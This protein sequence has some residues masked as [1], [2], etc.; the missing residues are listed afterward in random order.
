MNEFFCQLLDFFTK[1]GTY[2]S[3]AASL[4][5]SQLYDQIKDFRAKN[6]FESA[7]NNAVKEYNKNHSENLDIDFSDF[8]DSIAQIKNKD[9]I[10]CLA[11]QLRK[12]PHSY[13]YFLENKLND[14][15]QSNVIDPILKLDERNC[16]EY[17]DKFDFFA[18]Y[19]GSDI[20]ISDIFIDPEYKIIELSENGDY[21][22]KESKC[23]SGFIDSCKKILN[24]RRLLFISGPY[25]HGKTFLSKL[26]LS[27]IEDG[28]SFF[29]YASDLPE[30]NSEF[31]KTF[32]PK[33]INYFV[34]RYEKLYIFIDSFEDLLLVNTLKI[35]E[36]LLEIHNGFSNVYFVI[37]YR[38]SEGL[39]PFKD[40]YEDLRVYWNV[41]KVIELCS[42]TDSKTEQWMNSYSA[43]MENKPRKT[44]FTIYDIKKANK[45][46]QKSFHN[47][48][49]LLIMSL[50]EETPVDIN[51]QN[52]YS[53]FDNFVEKTVMGKYSEE[54]K[55][56]TFLWLR[57]KQK[58]Y[59]QFITEAA[60]IILKNNKVHYELE[61]LTQED[62]FLDQNDT[63]KSIFW[64]ED[65]EID[66]A[67]K[68]ILKINEK[69]KSK[70]I[71]RYLNCYFFECR[72]KGNSRYWKFRDNNILFFLCAS[73]I[74]DKLKNA[75]DTCIKTDVIDNEKAESEAIN[76]LLVSAKDTPLHPVIIEFLINEISESKKHKPSQIMSLIRFLIQN[77]KIL[78]VP[79]KNTFIL[80]Y[81]KINS[82]ILFFILYIHFHEDS[83][84]DNYDSFIFKRVTHYYSFI[85]NIDTDLA[86][87]IRRYFKNVS[88]IGV[89][90][91]G[92]NVKK[93][94]WTNS[95]ITNV[96]FLRCKID[97]SVFTRNFFRSTLFNL[98][99]IKSI[100]FKDF[101]GSL[102]FKSSE[103][104]RT[105]F[106]IPDNT[107]FEYRSGAPTL[108]FNN[109]IL[110]NVSI[111]SGP[112]FT[113]NVSL[114]N[115]D[116]RQL[117]LK[118]DSIRLHIEDSFF[119]APIDLNKTKVTICNT[120]TKSILNNNILYNSIHYPTPEDKPV[121]NEIKNKLFVRDQ[122]SA[123]LIEP[124]NTKN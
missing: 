68:E 36:Q 95:K 80:D 51:S 30:S 50:N 77:D 52:W 25:G 81:R 104:Y 43:M 42:F 101:G 78:Q 57:G 116:V 60:H 98:C 20:S 72:I 40:I 46:I 83:Y 59:K 64:V 117:H 11:E 61:K 107:V 97:E 92:I 3:L 32:D 7:F 63:K 29:F 96:K 5:A 56:N 75:Y 111:S 54:G 2:E 122:G 62:Y 27:E 79:D 86:A 48:L 87:V 102:E 71:E 19:P 112:E 37:N 18:I 113:P 100:L 123:I 38:T 90:F 58:E 39:R 12:S 121:M 74:C 109:C 99:Y 35:Q 13:L 16:A 45:N 14:I 31:K 49:L 41:E 124:Y 82:D 24:E 85:K 105:E 47:P 93:Y 106:V 88:I 103:L 66:D 114:I 53:H 120:S 21:A 1:P 22:E 44:S 115:C 15:N 73:R 34:T 55:F 110:D 28:I 10:D 26:L 89:Q 119:D 8:N 108:V 17:K 84:I 4:I 69:D 6:C 65:N 70:E 118:C 67:L 91:R 33:A 9:F 94:N 23:S 76:L